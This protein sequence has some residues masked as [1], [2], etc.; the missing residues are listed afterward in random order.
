[1]HSLIKEK[2]GVGHLKL[3][4]AE[5]PRVSKDEVLVK[6]EY[7]GI[8]GTDLHILHDTFPYNPPVIIG[9]EFSGVI[10]DKGENVSSLL[11]VGDSVAVQGSTKKTC[12]HCIYCKTGNYMLCSERLGMGHGV[13]G[14]FTKYVNVREDMIYKAGDSVNLQKLALAEPLACAVQAVEEFVN[15]HSS[16]TVLVSGPGPIGLLCTAILKNKGCTVIFAGTSADE[17][18]LE[19]AE[20]LGSDY[21]VDISNTNL[22]ALVKKV[23]D[24]GVD[25]A[26]ECA[27]HP[28]S[29]STCIN[30]LKPKGNLL[31]VGITSGDI[32]IDYSKI[33]LKN[34][35]IYGSLAHSM[36]SWEKALKFIEK[37]SL[38]LDPIITHVLPLEDWEDGF[39]LCESKNCGK[40]L[41]KP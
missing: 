4:P 2:Q 29:V 19:I 15:I 24:H 34:L 1:M 23:T 13:N 27:G 7:C 39:N 20:Q 5:T 38:S 35:A 11:N 3:Y 6:V 31:Q 36:T 32:K 30:C 17:K 22:E 9:H 14:G 18:R 10:V 41:L 8:C 26:F 25:A 37:D 21:V 28:S 40:V 12:G 33:V 16:D